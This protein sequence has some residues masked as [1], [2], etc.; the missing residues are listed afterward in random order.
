MDQ[1]KRPKAKSFGHDITKPKAMCTLEPPERR[2]AESERR[3]ARRVWAPF[4]F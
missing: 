1:G 2:L 3:D 4:V